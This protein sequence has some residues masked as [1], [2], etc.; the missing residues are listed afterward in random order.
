MSKPLWAYSGFEPSVSEMLTDPIVCALM[1][2]DGIRREELVALIRR[3][4]L[5]APPICGRSPAPPKN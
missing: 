3:M 1:K 4:S 5:S 2:A